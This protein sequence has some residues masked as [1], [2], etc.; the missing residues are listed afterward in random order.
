MQTQRKLQLQIEEQGKYL[1]K[2]FEQHKTMGNKVK[3][4]SSTASDPDAPMSNT[5]PHSAK[6]DKS[7]TSE[8]PSTSSATATLDEGFRDASG[9]QKAQETKTHDELDSINVGS[10]SP[11]AKRAR[12]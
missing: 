12:N 6:H 2:M 5:V 4:S 7:E 3:A 11:P 1:Q 10:N 9:K 8:H